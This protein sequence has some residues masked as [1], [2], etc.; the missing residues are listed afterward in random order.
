MTTLFHSTVRLTLEQDGHMLRLDVSVKSTFKG[1][2]HLA[3]AAVSETAKMLVKAFEQKE[4]RP[5]TGEDTLTLTLERCDG[6]EKDIHS[7]GFGAEIEKW[8]DSLSVK[9]EIIS[10]QPSP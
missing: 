4:G 1:I 9:A 7:T 8:L 2:G 6:N 10:T 3:N 5:F